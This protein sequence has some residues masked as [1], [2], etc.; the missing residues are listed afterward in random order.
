M[1]IF[2]DEKPK[3]PEKCLFSTRDIPYGE[4][5]CKL[6]QDGDKICDLERWCECRVLVELNPS[7][8]YDAVNSELISRLSQSESRLT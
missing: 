5:F 7:T 3:C 2:C 8:I 6:R 1:K 4:Y